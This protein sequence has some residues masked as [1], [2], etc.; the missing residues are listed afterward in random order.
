MRHSADPSWRSHP[1][2]GSVV[3]Y[4]CVVADL[5]CDHSGFRRGHTVGEVH[6]S[7]AVIESAG[8]VHPPKVAASAESECSAE[9]PAGQPEIEKERRGSFQDFSRREHFTTC[10]AAEPD[11]EKGRRES[12]SCWN[13]DL[14]AAQ[15]GLDARMALTGVEGCG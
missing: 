7:K 4:S 12:N 11:T 8:R 14:D 5:R 15:Q 2:D 3:G 9:G 6:R 10:P 1:W 13:D